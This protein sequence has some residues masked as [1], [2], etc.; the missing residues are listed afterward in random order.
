MPLASLA[1]TALKAAARFWFVVTVI[2][3]LIFAFAVASFYGSYG[4]ARGLALRGSFTN[5]YV[6]GDTMG[7]FAVAMHVVRPSSSC[8]PGAIQL[9]PQI[10]KRFPAFH[11]WNGRVYMLTAVTL[12]VAG[13][14]MTWVRGSVGDHSL[15][16]WLPLWTPS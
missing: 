4:A 10:R 2:G 12:S 8:S 9:V 6:P 11:R 15:N 16:T 5:G 3:Q 7:N 14:Y 1:D 13:L